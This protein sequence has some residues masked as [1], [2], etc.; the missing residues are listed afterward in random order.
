MILYCLKWFQKHIFV[1][2]L[3]LKLKSVWSLWPHVENSLAKA[4][5]R[6]PAAATFYIL[7]LKSSVN[8]QGKK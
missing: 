5:P 7:Q 3:Q 4:K 2:Y 6:P 1:G 8:I